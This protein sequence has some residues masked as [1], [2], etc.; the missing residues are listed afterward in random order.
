MM[1]W[2]VIVL[3]WMYCVVIY[4]FDCGVWVCGD[5]CGV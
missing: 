3:Y 4:L 1:I 2:M 5:V